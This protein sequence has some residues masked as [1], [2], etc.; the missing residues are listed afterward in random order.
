MKTMR[1]SARARGVAAAACSAVVGV[2]GVGALAVGLGA[3]LGAGL[4]GCAG[5]REALVQQ[6]GGDPVLAMLDESLS[7][8]S[9][10]RAVGLAWD[11]VEA[12][13]LERPAMRESIKSRLLWRGGP[14]KVRVA[15]VEALLRDETPEGVADNKKV[16]T[17]LLPTEGDYRVIEA[18]ARNA[19]ERGWMDVAPGLVRSLARHLVTIAD[20]ERA[21]AAA[22]RTL[23][24]EKSL[25]ESIFAVFMMSEAALNQPPDLAR[26]VRTD[27]YE[28]LG[29]LDETGAERARL[30][31]DVEPARAAADPLIADLAAGA[32]ELGVVPLTSSELDW[33]SDLRAG[34]GEERRA[35]QRWWS[36][37]AQAVAR[38]NET[39]KQGLRLRHI[40]PIRWAA[41]HEPA[42]LDADFESLYE[43]LNA[44]LSEREHHRRTDGRGG[45]QP[46]WEQLDRW[47]D[48]LAWGDLVTMLIV[49]EAVCGNASPAV[50]ATLFDH[51]ERDRADTTTEYGGVIAALASGSG[52][53]EGWEVRLYPPRPAQRQDDDT[54]VA[55]SQMFDESARALAHHHF[56]ASKVDRRK[57]AGPGA[58]DRDYADRHGRT[59]IVFTSIDADTLGVDVYFR[60]G[61]IVDLGTIRRPRPGE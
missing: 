12:G 58:A 5:E 32:R 41:A 46:N 17:L 59:C 52:G 31:A 24:P 18:I 23:Y 40:E 26:K 47:R 45:D 30:L 14:T 3:G 39:Q 49:D 7:E 2:V 44:R 4:V 6:V 60:G 54:F 29:R 1:W 61:P 11:Q 43:Q 10:A 57:Y 27:A 42:L 51:L 20:E 15:A 35:N 48:K 8:H 38:L 55:S 53:G 9:R 37:A 22:L 21:E 56:H 28:L 34:D 36:Q 50:R 13:E 19:A 33:L 25:T 16:F